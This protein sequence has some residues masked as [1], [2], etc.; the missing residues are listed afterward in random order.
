MTST[1]ASLDGVPSGPVP[2]PGDG[3]G[4]ESGV[5]G[6]VVAI[7]D[8]SHRGHGVGTLADGRTVFV[9][10]T[11]PGDRAHIR[12]VTGKSR[13]ARGT[14]LKLEEHSELRREPPCP[15]YGRCGGCQLQHLRYRD[16]VAW[17]GHRVA[18]TLAR[19][20]DRGVDVPPV[21]PSAREFGYRNRISFT[22]KRLRSGRVLAGLHELERPDRIVEIRDECLLPEK[23][24]LRVWA[25]LRKGWGPGARLLPPGGRLRLTLRRTGDG[26]AL[27]IQGGSLGGDAEALLERV[28][29]LV[30]VAHEPSDGPLR[31]LAGVEAA[32]DRWFG[33]EIPV[34]SSAFMQ[35]NREGAEGLHLAVLKELGNPEGLRVVDAYCG[36]GAY[37]RRLAHHGA[38]VTGIELDPY[39]VR[40][41]RTGA[42]EDF[43][44][45]EGSVEEHLARALPADLVILNPPRAGVDAEATAVLRESDVARIVYV[46]C[47]PA[48]LARDLDR[49]GPGFRIRQLRAFDL[50]PQTAHVETMT[51]LEAV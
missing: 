12:V 32:R 15:V 13:W 22:L 34:S 2:G 33:A 29:G 40:V 10:R 41:A 51:V 9:P 48:T 21:E 3:G 18:E 31:H 5:T 35:V 4:G 20:G 45:L 19:I 17:K 27:V 25:R 14:L 49:L 7:R 1:S 28:E 50:F 46:S 47:D 24:V 16:Q 38:K 44:V 37:G 43:T 26:A 39:A 36:V 42:P 30:S 11:A 23:P 8:L 6:Q